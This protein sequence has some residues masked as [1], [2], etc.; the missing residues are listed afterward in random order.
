MCIIFLLP[1]IQSFNVCLAIG[2]DF[3]DIK[4]AVANDEISFSNCQYSNISECIINETSNQSMSCVTMNYLLSKNYKLVSDKYKLS[5]NSA[6]SNNKRQFI[7]NIK[8]RF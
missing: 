6:K 1:I 7:L 5:I 8:Q 4:I 3:N 2:R